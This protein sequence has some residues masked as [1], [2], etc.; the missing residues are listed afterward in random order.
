M[1][2]LLS[3]QVKIQNI[4]LRKDID[5]KKGILFLDHCNLNGGIV[6]QGDTTL[7]QIKKSKI[8]SIGNS[9]RCQSRIIVEDSEVQTLDLSGSNFSSFQRTAIS[10]ILMGKRYS[11]V[12]PGVDFEKNPPHFEQCKIIFM[13]IWEGK[14]RFINCEFIGDGINK[15]ATISQNGAGIFINCDFSGHMAKYTQN[16]P[17][18]SIEGK[19]ISEFRKCK[20]HHVK[21]AGI[22]FGEDAE[23]IM[24]DCEIYTNEIGIEIK[25]GANPIIRKCTVGQNKSIGIWVHDNGAGLVEN[26]NLKGNGQAWKIEP[27]CPVQRMNNV[28]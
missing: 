2:R 23:G 19:E 3:D 25:R 24:E 27:G 18:L 6:I 10:N 11:K 26:C 5:L 15:C 14:P 22:C 4:E 8:G 9:A 16:V 20:I 1:S 21:A 7:L 12:P 17:A 13:G 28:V